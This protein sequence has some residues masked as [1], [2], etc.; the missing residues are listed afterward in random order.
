MEKELGFYEKLSKIQ[1]EI[2]IKKEKYNSFGNYSFR[3]A[4]DILEGVKEFLKQEKLVINLSDD[5]HL[6]GNRIYIRSVATITD[7]VTFHSASAYAR[8]PEN[9]K[10]KMDESQTTGSASSYARKYALN[11]LLALDDGNDSDESE[12]S[13]KAKTKA[14]TIGS[15]NMDEINQIINKITDKLRIL[16]SGMNN[17]EK[18]GF[19]QKVFGV[20]SIKE[21]NKKPASELKKKL[22]QLEGMI[23]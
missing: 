1:S 20:T 19:I 23:K 4:E 3:S 6:I 9:P 17:D 7:G 14:K 2:K 15:E 5:L 13:K 18:V 12:P 22:E 11:G 8:E 16:C 10:A 21:L